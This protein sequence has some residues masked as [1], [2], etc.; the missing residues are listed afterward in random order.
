MHHIP[1]IRA[2]EATPSAASDVLRGVDG[3][4]L[5]TVDM[6]PPLAAT[7]TIARL[8]EQHP[9]GDPPPPDVIKAAGELFAT[10]TLNGLTPEK[11]CELHARSAGVPISVS[12]HSLADIART[13]AKVGARLA[14]ERPAGA[15]GAPEPGEIRA[16]WLR[17]GDIMSVIAP[18]NNP[19]THTQ[20][21]HALAFGYQL[22]IRP[23]SR[24]VLTPA[25][26]IA[27]LL[28]AGVEPSRLSLLPGGHA[29]ADALVDA[30]DVSLVFGGDAAARRYGADPS[31]VLRGPGRSKILHTGDLTDDVLDVM[32]ES[33]AFDAGLRCTN[34]TAVLTDGDPRELAEALATRLSKLTPAPPQSP[35]A[36]LP[37]LPVEQARAM[38]AHLDSV[39]AGAV[40]VAAEGDGVAD[41]G[42]G[43][44]ALRSAVLHCDRSDHPGRRVELPFPCVWVL[45]WSRADGMAPLKDTL[46]L[47]IMSDDESLAL[48]ALGERSIRKVVFGPIPTYEAG[49]VSPHDGYLSQDLMEVRAY[50]TVSSGSRQ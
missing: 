3:T 20:W 17:R 32:Y 1:L 11:Y 41:L 30:A 26:L 46:A 8:R 19:G 44:A 4:P 22:V 7:L 31:V 21:I 48:A 49:P 50:G 33:V 10:G 13:C 18:S 42:D 36:Q 45:P 40:D 5:A 37:V 9:L 24:D 6:A 2:G 16:V 23:G 14:A 12:Q 15:L 28:T 35:A 29:T 39:R 47:T 43:S 38:R 25:R 27:A 34:T